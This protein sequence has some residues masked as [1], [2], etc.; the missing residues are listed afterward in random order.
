MVCS[1]SND[2]NA[3][4]TEAHRI[5]KVMLEDRDRRVAEVW[6]GGSELTQEITSFFAEGNT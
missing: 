6:P 2:N 3:L 5:A 4:I 1:S